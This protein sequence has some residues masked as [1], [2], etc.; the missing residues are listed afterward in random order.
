MIYQ[1]I[2]HLNLIKMLFLY[3]INGLFLAYCA[4]GAA[5]QFFFSAMGVF[6]KNRQTHKAKKQRKIAVFIPAYREDAVILESAKQALL[7]DYP[8]HL[9]H[10]IV[11]A[12]KLKSETI[13]TLKQMPL[14]VVE[15]AFE[16]STKSKALNK[17]LSALTDFHYD[18]AV[19]LDADNVMKMDFLER[20]NQHFEGG[21]QAIQGRRMAKNEQTGFALLD[22]ASED[23]NNHIL[24]KGH[25][26]MSL[27]ARLAGSGMAFDYR[28][29]ENVMASVD[30]IGGFDKEMELRLTRKGIDIEYDEN[31]IVYDEKVSQSQ[32]FSKQRSRWLAAQ[33]KYA[34]RFVPEGISQVLL[35]GNRDFFNK[36]LQMTLPPR[37]VLPF[38]LFFGT[39]LNAIFSSDLTGFWFISLSLNMSSFLL[40]MP[41]YCFQLKNIKMWLNVPMA[42]GATLIALTRIREASRHFIHTPHTVH[43]V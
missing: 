12:D 33:Y 5:Y 35:T 10:I 19:V 14:K 23:V 16:K 2:N 9:Y 1:L 13:A 20:I 18:I 38:A 27:S 36:T 17:A 37:L 26:K 22:A 28:L 34:R 42:F 21:V 25:R 41:K 43:S 8:A 40:A 24:C 31:V 15:V 4:W 32:Q 39:V 30:A 29:F 3:L 7:Q 6:Y 11:I